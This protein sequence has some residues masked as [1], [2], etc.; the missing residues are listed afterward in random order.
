MNP[1]FPNFSA[2]PL[3]LRLKRRERSLLSAV[4]ETSAVSGERLRLDAEWQG[5]HER[6]E[7]LRAY[8][9]QLRA[10]QADID[11]RREPESSTSV[12]PFPADE[13]S[14]QSAWDKLIRARELLEAEQTHLRDDRLSMKAELA[15]MHRRQAN[16]AT[17]EALV[18]AREERAAAPEPAVAE[19]IAGQHTMSVMTRLTRSPYALARSVLRGGK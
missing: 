4:A 5:L 9:V 8:E 13:L 12:S 19:P 2:V 14:L 15:N 1:P 16:L 10:M 3:E 18:S 7:N 6:E 17:R 11:A